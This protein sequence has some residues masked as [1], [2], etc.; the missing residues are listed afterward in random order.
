LIANVIIADNGEFENLNKAINILTIKQNYRIVSFAATD[1]DD[2]INYGYA[3]M[4][5]KENEKE[6]NN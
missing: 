3:I 4:E 2:G 6:G 1:I 5:R